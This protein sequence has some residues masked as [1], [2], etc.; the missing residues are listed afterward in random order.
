MDSLKNGIDFVGDALEVG[1]WGCSLRN[2]IDFLMLLG[3]GEGVV[4]VWIA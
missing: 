2:G 3:G 1:G 4:Y